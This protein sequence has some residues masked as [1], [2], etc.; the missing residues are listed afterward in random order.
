MLVALAD[1]HTA[2]WYLAADPRLSETAKALM[3]KDQDDGNQVGVSAISLIEIVY[4]VE[5]E[6]IPRDSFVSLLG[7][8]ANPRNI[9]TEIAVDRRVAAAMRRLPRTAIPDMP[10]RII[11]ATALYLKVP[12]ISRDAKIQVSKVS[13]IW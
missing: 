4:L 7:A 12:L 10:D 6:R 3:I 5:K 13:T 2:V 8:L 9:L 1:T 11:A